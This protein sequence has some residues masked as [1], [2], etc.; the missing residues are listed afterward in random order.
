MIYVQNTRGRIYDTEERNW[1][2]IVISDLRYYTLY[3]ASYVD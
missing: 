1:K 2:F 3:F